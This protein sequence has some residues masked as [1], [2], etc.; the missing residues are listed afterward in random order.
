MG[1]SCSPQSISPDRMPGESDRRGPGPKIHLWAGKASCVWFKTSGIPFWGFRCTTH[2]RTDFSG[3]WDVQ[4]VPGFDASWVFLNVE[5]LFSG[6]EKV[7][8]PQSCLMLVSFEASTEK[9]K[10]FLGASSW[11]RLDTFM[12]L[13]A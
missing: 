8:G 13:P 2:F 1:V 9:I 5:H 12:L 6:S 4:G 10:R 11:T 7:G 3:D